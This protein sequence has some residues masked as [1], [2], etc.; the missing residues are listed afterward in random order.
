MVGVLPE[1][2]MV[3]NSFQTA[4]LQ[5]I[6][7]EAVVEE[8]STVVEM[9]VHTTVTTVAVIAMAETA[10]IELK[11]VVQNSAVEVKD[12]HQVMAE[13][14]TV[15]DVLQ[16]DTVDRKVIHAVGTAAVVQTAADTAEI[17]KDLLVVSSAEAVSL[18]V[19]SLEVVNSE[20]NLVA[21]VAL[22]AATVVQA[23]TDVADLLL[24]Q[25]RHMVEV[26]EEAEALQNAETHPDIKINLRLEVN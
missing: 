17:Q 10:E 1:K 9:A 13:M 25:V 18:A 4:D 6:T 3:E 24:D 26:A 5:T 14:Q 23:A 2:M 19:A 20:A 22:A 21:M 7:E 12:L 8:I 15:V 11:D 16:A